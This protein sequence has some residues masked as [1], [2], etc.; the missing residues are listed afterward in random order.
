MLDPTKDS[1]SWDLPLEPNIHFYGATTNITHL[2]TN[3]WFCVFFGGSPRCARPW[4]L[5]PNLVDRLIC[6]TFFT[7]YSVAPSHLH[8][9]WKLIV[10]KFR[11]MSTMNEHRV[12]P[13]GGPCLLAGTFGIRL[14]AEPLSNVAEGPATRGQC[15]GEGLGRRGGNMV[16][17]GRGLWSCWRHSILQLVE[18]WNFP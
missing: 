17:T 4:L 1:E 12:G 9:F 5:L 14:W 8:G 15:R 18:R 2:K 10:S 11:L 13:R 16:N 6:P 7:T 3:S